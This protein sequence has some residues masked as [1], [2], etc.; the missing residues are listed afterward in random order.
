M[1]ICHFI[2][3][4]HGYD[5]RLCPS[6]V[7][8]YSLLVCCNHLYVYIIET[9]NVG[10]PKEPVLMYCGPTIIIIVAFKSLVLL[11]AAIVC[12]CIR[13]YSMYVCDTSP[14]L[15]VVHV[16][17]QDLADQQGISFEEAKVTF[18]LSSL[19]ALVLGNYTF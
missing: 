2:H 18:E 17:F 6:V 12:L 16:Q 5:I 11:H 19:N 4:V 3:D 8:V 10:H 7:F 13:T 14:C 9:C 1:G 15:V